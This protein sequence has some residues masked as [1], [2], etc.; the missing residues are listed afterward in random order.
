MVW[1]GATAGSSA[2]ARVG[3]RVRA[4]IVNR[5]RADEHEPDDSR[6][7]TDELDGAERGIAEAVFLLDNREYLDWWMMQKFPGRT[8]EELDNVDWLRLM[9]AEDVGR[10]VDVEQRHQ[11]WLKRK[12]RKADDFTAA[13]WR[14][15]QRH[16]RLVGDNGDE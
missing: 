15:I 14:M 4:A 9:R 2:T 16:N 8:P 3:K 10:I 7:D 5:Q 13:E 1:A 12:D 11:A 6:A